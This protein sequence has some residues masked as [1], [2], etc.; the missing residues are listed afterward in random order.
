MCDHDRPIARLV[1]ATISTAQ[2]IRVTLVASIVVYSITT[3]AMAPN[4][5]TSSPIPTGPM[6]R[7]VARRK[8][9]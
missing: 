3:Q 7:H 2:V 8:M 4:S 1:A 6:E 5:T 9:M